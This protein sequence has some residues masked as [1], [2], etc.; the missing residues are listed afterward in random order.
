MTVYK[1][2]IRDEKWKY[3]NLNPSAPTMRGLLEV[4]KINSS[5]RPVI[6]WQNAPA[7]KLAKILSKLLQFYIP[8][9]S[10]FNIKKTQY[11]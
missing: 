3:V 7:Y 1:L 6:N 5:L 10:T 9:P 11:S 4:H 8:L 2:S